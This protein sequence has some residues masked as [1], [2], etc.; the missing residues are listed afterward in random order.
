L[1]NECAG[2]EASEEGS[3]EATIGYCQREAHRQAK[4]TSAD[5]AGERNA[6]ELRGIE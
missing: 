1:C 5:E 2:T 3:R 6:Q 4:A